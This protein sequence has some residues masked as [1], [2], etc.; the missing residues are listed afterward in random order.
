LILESSF[1]ELVT[2]MIKS[3]YT[4][5]FLEIAKDSHERKVESS[6]IEDIEK[7]LLE[8]GY[9]FSFIDNQYRLILSKEE[10]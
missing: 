6:L 10:L 1:S 3:E 2:D 7:I 4:L 9:G 5:E 8:L